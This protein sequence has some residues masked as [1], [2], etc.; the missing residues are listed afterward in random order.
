VGLPHKDPV[1]IEINVKIVPM[2]AKLFVI[3]GINFILN[4]KLK[5]DPIPMHANIPRAIKDEGT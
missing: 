4:I 1:I 2:G 3:K 5:I